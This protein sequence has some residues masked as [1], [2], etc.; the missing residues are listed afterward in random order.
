[1][2]GRLVGRR[3]MGREKVEFIWGKEGQQEQTL[4]V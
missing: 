4:R 2:F 1:M 3:E